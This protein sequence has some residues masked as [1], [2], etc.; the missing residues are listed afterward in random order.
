MKNKLDGTWWASV[1]SNASACCDPD[2]WPFDLISMS[3]AQAHAWPNFGEISSNIYR[4]TVFTWF[5]GSLLLWPWPLT[6]WPQ[7]LISTSTNQSISETKIGWNSLHS[8]L[9]Y[10]VHELIG[11]H[12][13]THA[14]THSLTDRQ[15][16]IHYASGTAFQW[17]RKYKNVKNIEH[18]KVCYHWLHSA[19]YVKCAFFLLWVCA[20]TPKFYRNRVISRQNVD[21]IR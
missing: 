8:F 10:G 18:K 9:R 7:N 21:T 6:F 11:L 5:Y 14:L 17:W 3:Q 4:D 12:R 2:L 20:F 16:W 13:L 15:T 1:D 19:P